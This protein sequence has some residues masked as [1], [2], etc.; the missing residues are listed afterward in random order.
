[1]IRR[2]QRFSCI[3]DL[4]LVT[5]NL[6]DIKVLALLAVN[7]SASVYVPT[8]SALGCSVMVVCQSCEEHSGNTLHGPGIFLAVASNLGLPPTTAGKHPSRWTSQ[9]SMVKRI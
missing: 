4:P 5:R 2:C 9:S 7:S 6:L 3:P 8:G 1:M